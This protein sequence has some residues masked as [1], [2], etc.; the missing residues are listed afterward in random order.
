MTASLRAGA[1]ALALLLLAPAVASG[2]GATIIINNINA[3]GVGF[4]DPTPV[5]PLPTNPGT[6]RG[7]QRLIVFQRAAII[8]GQ[9]ILSAVPIIVNAQFISQTCGPTSG[10]LGSAGTQSV[11]RDFPGAPVPA[12]WYHAALANALAGNDLDGAHDINANFNLNLDSDPNCLGGVGWYYGL[13]HT[14]G[15]QVDL[16]AVVEHELA[17]GL[18]FSNFVNLSTGTF[19]NGFQDTYS[20]LIFDNATGELWPQMTNGGRVASAINDPFVVW[21]GAAVAARAGNVLGVVPVVTVNS[22]GPIAGDYEA[23]AASYGPSVSAGSVTGNVVLVDDGTGLPNEGCSPLINGPAVSGNIA[24]V[25]RGTCTF[26][27][28][29]TNAQAAGAT[30]VLIANNVATGL[31]PMGGSDP[32][33]TI[34]SLGITQALGTSIKANLPAPGVNATMQDDPLGTLAGTDGG[35]L[36]LHAPSPLALGSSISHWTISAEP[37]LLMEPAINSNLTDDL[38]LTLDL[39]IDVGWPTPIFA[40]GFESGDSVRWSL[41]TP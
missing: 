11:S 32:L 39:F 10:V 16:L 14:E 3:P 5:A 7:Q 22:P 21:S 12:T 26:V 19:F 29:S 24:L 9:Q 31:P 23:Q 15:N 41:T 2:Q 30:G 33:A 36:R 6:T 20:R 18:G 4:N 17:H 13:D 27:Q 40:D 37:S 35:A 8:H 34:P 38:D 1:V 25:D 28:K